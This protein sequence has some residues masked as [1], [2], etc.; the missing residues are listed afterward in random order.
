TKADLARSGTS[1]AADGHADR[2]GPEV[3][4]VEA[5][6]AV[7]ALQ[8]D[9]LDRLLDEVHR[10]LERY[11]GEVHPELPVVTRERHRVA[12]EQAHDDVDRFVTMWRRP[13]APATV[14]AVHIRSAAHALE[15]LIGTVDVDDVLDR[16][17]R[18]FCVGK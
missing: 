17:F 10:V 9:G 15:E 3:H 13:S 2:D 14:A 11:V 4:G 1:V 6:V 8:R 12:L 5:T 7:S 18:T 16:V